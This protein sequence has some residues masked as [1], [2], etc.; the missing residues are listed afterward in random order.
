MSNRLRFPIDQMICLLYESTEA[1]NANR[2]AVEC[3]TRAICENIEVTKASTI[4][5]KE[6]E[7]QVKTIK[8]NR[9]SDAGS[10]NPQVKRWQVRRTCLF[11]LPT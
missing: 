3:S 9:T 6:N 8:D 10:A 11:Y 7:E 2:E 1:I 4:V 5:I